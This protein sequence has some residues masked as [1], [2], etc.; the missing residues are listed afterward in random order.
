M[1]QK[2]AFSLSANMQLLRKQSFPLDLRQRD[3][4]GQLDLLC[5]DSSNIV[6]FDF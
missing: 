3:G 6:R 5:G 2:R 4:N 1:N